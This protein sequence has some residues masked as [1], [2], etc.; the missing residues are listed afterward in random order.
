MRITGIYRVTVERNNE[1]PRYYIGQAANIA[2]RWRS[3]LRLLRASKHWNLGMQ[4]DFAEYGEAAFSCST[5]IICSAEKSILAMF[6]QI[7]VNAHDAASLYNIRIQCVISSLGSRASPERRAKIAKAITGMKRSD[8]TK[9]AISRAQAWKHTP[10]GK[11]K[12]SAAAKGRRHTPERRALMSQTTIFR[13]LPPEAYAKAQAT[14]A[15][16]RNVLFFGS[17]W[18]LHG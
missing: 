9:A 18:V 7:A 17:A 4:I 11:L 1:A 15:L 12:M 3:H 8:E 10:E 5:L 14:R 13:R 6:E 2:Q 16:K